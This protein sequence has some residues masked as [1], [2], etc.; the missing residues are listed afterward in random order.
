MEKMEENFR[1][2]DFNKQF[3]LMFNEK[4]RVER[5]T[6]GKVIVDRVDCDRNKLE[7][8]FELNLTKQGIETEARPRHSDVWSMIAL[9]ELASNLYLTDDNNWKKFAAYI[10]CT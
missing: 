8:L 4:L 10:G 7:S 2:D 1:G 9:K 5:G 6:F 3:A